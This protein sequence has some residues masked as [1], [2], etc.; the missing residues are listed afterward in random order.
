MDMY[1]KHPTAEGACP[2]RV[3]EVEAD[4][5]VGGTIPDTI[6]FHHPHHIL[7]L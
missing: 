5:E 3:E 6:H 4:V 7:R 2:I 1:M